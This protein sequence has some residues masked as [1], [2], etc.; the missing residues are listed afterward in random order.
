MHL[1]SRLAL[2]LP[3][4]TLGSSA[5]AEEG[6]PRSVELSATV[7]HINHAR[8]GIRP[9]EMMV[10]R[11]HGDDVQ[12]R[13]WQRNSAQPGAVGAW[14]PWATFNDNGR[15]VD[16][17]FWG[18]SITAWAGDVFNAAQG[19]FFPRHA[20]TLDYQDGFDQPSV[21]NALV[22]MLAFGFEHF[23]APNSN[24]NRVLH[25]FRPFSSFTWM[26]GNA[27]RVNVWG[28]A[29]V[30][31]VGGGFFQLRERF[32]DGTSW[33]FTDYPLPRRARTLKLGPHS[34]AWTNPTGNGQG[35]VAATDGELYV[36]HWNGA[37]WNWDELGTPDDDIDL[38][39]PVTLVHDSSVSVFVVGQDR[40]GARLYVRRWDGAQWQDWQDLG[41]PPAIV[42]PPN[43]DFSRT[44]FDVMAAVAWRNAAGV[45]RINVF[46]Q[47]DAEQTTTGRDLAAGLVEAFFDG[48]RW[49]WGRPAPVPSALQDVRVDV[50]VT[51]AEVL[52]WA[53][54]ERI[55][56]F[57]EDSRGDHWEF[58]WNGARWD[59]TPLQ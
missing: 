9:T 53:D 2:T 4:L 36:L 17:P 33:A 5:F 12:R 42:F 8:T 25:G 6:R 37:R 31:P 15:I 16:E 57:A 39:T 43:T 7:N 11:R 14:G 10:F 55:T 54:S 20:A 38:R 34:A 46:G 23:A 13:V 41:A 26:S 56:V 35:F 29:E 1:L 24:F 21:G 59:W 50:V 44:G 19:L 58:S 45:R 32:F 49:S 22:N 30:P 27:L 28:L 48:T 3:V 52:D 40:D 18:T 47:V 51:D